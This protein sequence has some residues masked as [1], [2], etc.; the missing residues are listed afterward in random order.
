MSSMKPLPHRYSTFLRD[1]VHDM[2]SVQRQKRPLAGELVPRIGA[3][4]SRWRDGLSE[5]EKAQFVR[6]GER[7]G[8][9][10]RLEAL[11]QG[12]GILI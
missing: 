3:A 5:Q 12:G 4:I 10:A 2:L 7:R 9:D 1:I 8:F 11:S 6:K